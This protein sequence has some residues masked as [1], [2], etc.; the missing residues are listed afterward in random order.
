[1]NGPIIKRWVAAW[2]GGA[3]IG[4]GNGVLREATY[5][6]Q[7]SEYRAHQISVLTAIAGFGVYFWRLQR[8][9]PLSD[10]RDALRVGQIWLGLTVLFE[11]S[12]GRLVAKKSWTDLLADYN[13]IRGRTW[14]LVLLWLWRGPAIIRGWQGR[15]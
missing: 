4:V 10:R 1:V 6:K 7:V 11:F 9:W 2:L 5:G 13:L 14:P 3:A 8:R 15:S 12:F